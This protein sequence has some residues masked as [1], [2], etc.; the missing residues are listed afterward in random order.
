MS[1]PKRAVYEFKKTR[2]LE[3]F[4]TNSYG[5]AGVS[6]DKSG[7]YTDD[8]CAEVLIRT[9]CRVASKLASQSVKAAKH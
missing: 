7:Y 9:V 3:E 4:L 5:T 6:L 2:D 1:V 8:E